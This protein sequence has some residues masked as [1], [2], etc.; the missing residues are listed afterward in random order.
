MTDTHP[1]TLMPKKQYT[2]DRAKGKAHREQWGR[3]IRKSHLLPPLCLTHFP[4][5]VYRIRTT[6]HSQSNLQ[7]SNPCQGDHTTQVISHSWDTE[8]YFFGLLS[9]ALT[10]YRQK[11]WWWNY[12]EQLWT[13]PIL[14]PIARFTDLCPLSPLPTPCTAL[15]QC[16]AMP[17]HTPV[18]VQSKGGKTKLCTLCT[19]LHS[20]SMAPGAFPSTHPQLR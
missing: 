16:H 14:C 9:S 19:A 8:R 12:E 7:N 11:L 20:T 15:P 4:T 10:A 2:K 5:T 1:P 17:W 18:F 6:L 3:I 13:W